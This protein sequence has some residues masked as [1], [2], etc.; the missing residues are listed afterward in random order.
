[1]ERENTQ[2]MYVISPRWVIYREMLQ[3]TSRNEMGAASSCSRYV[4]VLAQR[5]ARMRALLLLLSAYSN[6]SC[7]E[8]G[9]DAA[10]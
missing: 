7:S 2:N 3:A 6:F 5:R 4:C 1:M 8:P 9:G 10:W